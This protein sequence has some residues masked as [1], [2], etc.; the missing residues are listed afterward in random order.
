MSKSKRRFKKHF[1]INHSRESSGHPS[2]I[3][4][5]VGENYDSIGLT[6]SPI[7]DNKRNVKLRKNPNKRDNRASYIRPFF[8]RDPI[9]KFSKRRIRGWKF[10][11]RDKKRIRKYSRIRK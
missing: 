3:I 6:H 4:R 5:K 11:K 10:I 8:R 7:T 2:Y 9:K 1:R